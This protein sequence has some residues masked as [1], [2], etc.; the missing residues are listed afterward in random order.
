MNPVLRLRQEIQ[1]MLLRGD[2]E[3]SAVIPLT[4]APGP[5]CNDSSR[6]GRRS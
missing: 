4:E 3:L 2:G 1:A 6:R 5:K